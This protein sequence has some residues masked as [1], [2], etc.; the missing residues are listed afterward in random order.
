MSRPKGSK[1]KKKTSREAAESMPIAPIVPAVPL[2]I[3]LPSSVPIEP[4]KLNPAPIKA[5]L[6]IMGRI[7]KSEGGS[8]EEVIGNLKVGNWP[9]T[10][11]ILTIEKEGVKREKILSGRH[12]RSLFG[13]VSPTVKQIHLKWIKQIF[14][15]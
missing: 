9:K 10:A 13:L 8:F 7:Y 3:D 5:T 6:K 14:N 1:N 2:E 12:T 15:A 4:D 11:S